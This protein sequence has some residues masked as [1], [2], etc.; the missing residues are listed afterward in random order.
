MID[1]NLCNL[2]KLNRVVDGTVLASLLNLLK[3]WYC[4][5]QLILTLAEDAFMMSI[6]HVKTGTKM[7]SK[8]YKPPSRTT[9]ELNAQNHHNN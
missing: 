3:K 5:H 1:K 8:P 2:P 4:Q 6:R 9:M 7:Q